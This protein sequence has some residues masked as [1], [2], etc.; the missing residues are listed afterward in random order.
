MEF[1]IWWCEREEKGETR[2]WFDPCVSLICSQVD[3]GV[4]YWG[5]KELEE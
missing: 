1:C 3:Y 5:R 4:S 2:D